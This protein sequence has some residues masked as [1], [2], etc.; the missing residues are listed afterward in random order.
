MDYFSAVTQNTLSAFHRAGIDT[1][2]SEEIDLLRESF[3]SP[4]PLVL[5]EAIP[6]PNDLIKRIFTDDSWDEVPAEELYTPKLPEVT[7]TSQAKTLISHALAQELSPISKLSQARHR[8]GLS[9]T[10][11][12]ITRLSEQLFFF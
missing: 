4:K 7:L 3:R 6:L 5:R 1:V 12:P 9:C 10:R 2:L 8:H 11:R